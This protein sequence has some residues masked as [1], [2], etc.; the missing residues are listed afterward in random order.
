MGWAAVAPGKRRKDGGVLVEGL[1]APL[2]GAG[3]FWAGFPRVALRFT[4]GYFHAVPPGRPAVG[5]TIAWSH[6]MEPL[7]GAI[8]WSRRSR[9]ARM[10]WAAVAP[11]KRRKRGHCIEKMLAGG[12]H[13]FFRGAWEGP[14]AEA[15]FLE[16]PLSVA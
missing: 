11:G 8:A 7:H 1:T 4:R 16:H 14:A 3:G 5:Q 12:S 6:C 2:R 9:E 10:G 13:G 15:G